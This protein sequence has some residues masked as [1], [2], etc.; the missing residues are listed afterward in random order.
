MTWLAALAT[1]FGAG[2]F[3]FGGLWLTVRQFVLRS[4]PRRLTFAIGA[5]RMLLVGLCFYWLSRQGAREVLAGLAGLWLAR[6]WLVE[7]LGGSYA[8]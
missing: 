4:Q 7:R 2:L 1:G 8:R 6:W 3:S 5:V